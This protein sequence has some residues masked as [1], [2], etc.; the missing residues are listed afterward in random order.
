VPLDWELFVEV[1]EPCDVEEIVLRLELV[2][3]DNAEEVEMDEVEDDVEEPTVLVVLVE[4]A[5]DEVVEEVVPP[6]ERA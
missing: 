4:P 5:D 1:L 6:L 3:D 2:V